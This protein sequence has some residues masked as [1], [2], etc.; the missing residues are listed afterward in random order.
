MTYPLFET[1][2]VFDLLLRVI[3]FLVTLVITSKTLKIIGF[4]RSLVLRKALALSI[5]AMTTLWLPLIVLAFCL[6]LLLVAALFLALRMLR[7]T[8]VAYQPS[9]SSSSGRLLPHAKNK[10]GV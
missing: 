2:L 4:P 7:V 1:L 6:L 8:R 10:G 5:A 3:V 9:S